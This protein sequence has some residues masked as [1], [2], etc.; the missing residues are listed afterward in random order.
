V[1]KI[2]HALGVVN[3]IVRMRLVAC[4]PYVMTY[5]LVLTL[6]VLG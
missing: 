5:N 1:S 4:M 2:A 3:E 6:S